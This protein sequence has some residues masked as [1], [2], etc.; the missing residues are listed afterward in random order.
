MTGIQN[1]KRIIRVVAS[2]TFIICRQVQNISI[3]VSASL[4]LSLSLRLRSRLAINQ[5]FPNDVARLN[6]AAGPR[7]YNRESLRSLLPTARDKFRRCRKNIHLAQRGLIWKQLRRRCRCSLL[8]LRSTTFINIIYI[9]IY[10][11][12]P[13]LSKRN[14]WPRSRE[15]PRR[16]N[17]S[18][19]LEKGFCHIV[20]LSESN[21]CS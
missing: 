2:V 7:S 20:N 4:S 8:F 11:I 19:I 5:K 12:H 14:S 3:R 1:R 9:Y 10:I 6:F 15:M 18:Y 21:F 13:I 17:G 16:L